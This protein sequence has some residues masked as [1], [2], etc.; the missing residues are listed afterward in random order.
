MKK[1][2]VILLL[3][4]AMLFYSGVDRTPPAT[5]DDNLIMG[6]PSKAKAETSLP[7][8][9]LITKNQYVLSYN[10]K[11][12][13]P[14]WV[15]WHLST[16]WK[17]RY[18]R[19]DPFR[20]DK[21]VPAPWYR[22]SK[23][24]YTNSG[25]DKGHICP[26]D[27]RDAGKVDNDAT[28]YMTNMIPQSPICNRQTWGDLE[29]YCRELAIE[30]NELFIVAGPYGKKGQGEKGSATFLKNGKVEVPKFVWKVILVLPNGTDDVSRVD[31]ATRVIA[32]KIPN[33]QNS[34]I[35]EWYDYRVSVDAIEQ[36]TGYDFFSAVKDDVE[37][38]IEKLV[39]DVEMD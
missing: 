1:I 16:A 12:G 39:D 35:K 18:K 33:K 3:F 15:S 2:N 26:S 23:K 25:F 38:E 37:N 27:D 9:Y 19:K 22:V 36:M 30:G 24:D 32:V 8:N 5:R 31:A 28:F 34:N 21:D 4:S 29:D 20:A 14:N 13:I 17:G 10:S 7:E 11:K 6:N